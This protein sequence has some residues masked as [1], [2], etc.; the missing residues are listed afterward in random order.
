MACLCFSRHLLRFDLFFF[1]FLFGR[2]TLLRKPAVGSPANAPGRG[3]TEGP[4]AASDQRYGGLA[5]FLR[6]RWDFRVAV[7]LAGEC[8]CHHAVEMG[9]NWP[10]LWDSPEMQILPQCLLLPLLPSHWVGESVLHL[11]KSCEDHGHQ[12]SHCGAVGYVSS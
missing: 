1:F 7:T 4:L 11:I 3:V 5:F 12:S 10:V 2:T 8:L 6:L 9:R